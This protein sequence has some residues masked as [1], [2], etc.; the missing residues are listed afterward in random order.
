VSA[1]TDSHD[2]QVP[3]ACQPT[4]RLSAAEREQ[5]LVKCWMSHDA[6][7]YMAAAKQFGMEAANRLNQAAVHDAGAAE[8]QRI[9]RALKLPAPRTLDEYLTVQRAII[10]LLGPDLLDYE[11]CVLDEHTYRLHVERCFA[12]E[13][14]SRAGVAAE[15]ECGVVARMMGWLDGLGLKYELSPRLGK[16]LKAEG[17]ECIYTI[18][19]GDKVEVHSDS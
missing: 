19:L 11:V 6:R 15:Y 5:L 4:V 7:W 10:D 2:A 8:A 13:N 16:C 17:R 1:D 9:V 14:V 12:Y 3:D 18:A